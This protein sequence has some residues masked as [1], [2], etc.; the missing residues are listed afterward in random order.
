M[1]FKRYVFS[2]VR[3]LAARVFGGK[4]LRAKKTVHKIYKRR[5]ARNMYAPNAAFQ[6]NVAEGRRRG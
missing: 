5:P 2:T 1:F 4:V 3:V 6:A